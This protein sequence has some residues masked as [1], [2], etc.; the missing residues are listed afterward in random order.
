M[1]ANLKSTTKLYFSSKTLQA[2]QLKLQFIAAATK[3]RLADKISCS[4]PTFLQASF[5]FSAEVVP[6]TTS[7]AQQPK[8]SQS[9][10]SH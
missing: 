8:L 5:Q 1:L 9:D 4:Q 7:E 3:T 10:L 2:S 6:N